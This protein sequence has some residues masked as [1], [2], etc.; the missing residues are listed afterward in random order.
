M[1]VGGVPILLSIQAGANLC[2]EGLGR[3]FAVLSGLPLDVQCLRPWIAAQVLVATTATS[4]VFL[5]AELGSVGISN[6]SRTP[7]IAL[8]FA[9]SKRRRSP[10]K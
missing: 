9:A 1:G 7:G 2:G 5:F 10:R 3:L 8:P 6:T 4:R